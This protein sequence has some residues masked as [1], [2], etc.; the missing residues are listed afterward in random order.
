MGP[1]QWLAISVAAIGF[2][3]SIFGALAA[4][5]GVILT[6]RRSD[7]RE[8]VA[9]ERERRREY[10]RWERE[11][12]S[13]TFDLKREA[14]IEYFDAIGRYRDELSRTRGERGAPSRTRFY[15]FEQ[16]LSLARTKIDI[17]GSPK[18]KFLAHGIEGAKNQVLKGRAS[19]DDLIEQASIMITVSILRSNLLEAM[20]MDLGIIPFGPTPLEAEEDD[21][22]TNDDDDYYFDDWH[23]DDLD[24]KSTTPAQEHTDTEEYT[25]PGNKRGD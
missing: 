2:T 18:I 19:G 14:Y 11:D 6:Q 15:G 1:S 13:R 21:T 25:P 23:E 8:N 12:A 16:E 10:A 20:R 17:Y 22:F 4:L 9:W 7:R 5:G 3:G 24:G